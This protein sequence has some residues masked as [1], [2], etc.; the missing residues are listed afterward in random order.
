MTHFN[1]PHISKGLLPNTVTIWGTGHQ[2]F[3]AWVWGKT[4][5]LVAIVE[6]EQPG[7]ACPCHGSINGLGSSVTSYALPYIVTN[8]CLSSES[9]SAQSWTEFQVLNIL[10]SYICIPVFF[11]T[12]ASWNPDKSKLM[13]VLIVLTLI[14]TSNQ[15]NWAKP[16]FS[17]CLSLKNS[18]L[19]MKLRIT[20]HNIC[21]KKKTGWREGSVVKNF[22]CSWRWLEFLSQDPH[23]TAYDSL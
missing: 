21:L 8:F 22:C 13:T 12:Q 5:H 1:L 19:K 20:M 11:P 10:N 15:S 4:I 17:T 7:Y 23:W 3:R 14:V 6:S 18:R 2:G 16:Q 9:S